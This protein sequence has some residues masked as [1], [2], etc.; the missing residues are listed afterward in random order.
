MIADIDSAV[1]AAGSDAAKYVP[2][3]LSEVQ[4]KL[5]DL[6]ASFDKGDYKAVINAAPPVL[7]D[8]QALA[9]AATAKKDLVIRGFNQQWASIANVLPGNATAIANRIEFLGKRENKK[10]AAGVDLDEAKAGLADAQAVWAKAQASFTEGDLENAV[11]TAKAA[12][13]KF[14]ALA[15]SMKLDLTQPA[16]VRDTSP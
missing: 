12:K 7:S 3:Q 10:L 1:S 2:D 4:K 5:G 15:A 8:A 14:D 9:G 6:R 13:T 11:A 16:A